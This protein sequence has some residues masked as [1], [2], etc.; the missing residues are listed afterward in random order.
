MDEDNVYSELAKRL[1]PGIY[2]QYPIRYRVV[3]YDLTSR[4]FVVKED[5]GFHIKRQAKHYES[6]LDDTW[7]DFYNKWINEK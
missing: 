2:Y 4:L 1:K 7:K 5:L 6:L 3:G